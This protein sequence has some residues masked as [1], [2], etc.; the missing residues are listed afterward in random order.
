MRQR[1]GGLEELGIC[2]CS[3]TFDDPANGG[4]EGMQL[5]AQRW[6]GHGGIPR[7][8][9]GRGV[10]AEEIESKELK[11]SSSQVGWGRGAD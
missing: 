3:Y 11:P 1:R 10:S 5:G 2:Y 8:S 7:L 4:L 6:T 9:E